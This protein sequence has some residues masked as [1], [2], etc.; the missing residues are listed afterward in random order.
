MSTF[1]IHLF[2]TIPHIVQCL[3]CGKISLRLK[4]SSVLRLAARKNEGPYIES[5]GHLRV[6][7][8]SCDSLSQGTVIM[9]EYYNF[10]EYLVALT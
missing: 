1:K 6:N 9:A 4:F 5:V 3:C 8:F 7:D 2:L 10:A